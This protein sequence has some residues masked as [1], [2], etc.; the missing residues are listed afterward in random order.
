MGEPTGELMPVRIEVLKAK[1]ALRRALRRGESLSPEF[2]RLN[3]GILGDMQ[4]SEEDGIVEPGRLPWARYRFPRKQS[5]D[6]SDPKTPAI[7]EPEH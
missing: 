6:N 1:R 7:E 2:D 3:P 5:I 4:Q